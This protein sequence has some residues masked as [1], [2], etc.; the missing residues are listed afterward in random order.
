MLGNTD[1]QPR[2]SVDEWDTVTPLP[3]T[4][5]A[6]QTPAAAGPWTRFQPQQ[7]AAQAAQPATDWSKFVPDE[8][9]AGPWQKFQSQ[10]LG[11][12]KPDPTPPPGEMGIIST[13]AQIRLVL[14]PR[15]S[16][17]L[18]GHELGPIGSRLRRLGS[19]LL[20]LGLVL[21]PRTSS[22]LGLCGGS[23]AR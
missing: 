11:Q 4:P 9:A 8:P 3:G 15:A 21:L 1:K 5:A 20:G 19:G 16:S 6:G 2:G 17:G 13:L 22:G 14:L 18:I 12:F 23:C 7:P 10:D